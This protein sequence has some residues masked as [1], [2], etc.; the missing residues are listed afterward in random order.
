[1]V[2]EEKGGSE[3][4][5]NG[6][7]VKNKIVLLR[8]KLINLSNFQVRFVFNLIEITLILD[9]FRFFEDIEHDFDIFFIYTFNTRVTLILTSKNFIRS[10]HIESSAIT[11]K[12]ILTL[13][14]FNYTCCSSSFLSIILRI[15]LSKVPG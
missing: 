6:R 12:T 15:F 13:K 9:S 3:E 7:I 1:M 11:L 2:N 8:Q 4:K 10:F 14:T 5:S